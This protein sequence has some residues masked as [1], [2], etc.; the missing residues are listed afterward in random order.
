MRYFEDIEIGLEETAGPYALTEREIT[1]FSA[2]WDP[3]EFHTDAEEADSSL[4]K[5]LAA[6]GVHTQC[7]SNRLGHDIHPW[8]VHAALGAE[9]RW[10]AAARV[11]DEL[12][13]HRQ[14]TDKRESRSRPDVGIVQHQTRLVNQAGVTVLESTVSLFV[15]RR[16]VT[17]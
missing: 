6:S 13:L 1:E 5:G 3:F 10:P 14:V 9:S 4:F 17:S 2:K 11:G 16:P 12:T 7:I 15:G 8:D